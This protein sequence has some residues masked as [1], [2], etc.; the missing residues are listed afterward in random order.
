[1]S[2][3]DNIQTQSRFLEGVVSSISGQNTIKVTVSTLKQHRRYKKVYKSSKSYLAHTLQSH[4]IGDK[5]RLKVVRPISKRKSM[6]V[7][8]GNVEAADL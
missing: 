3:N 6:I 5:V 7:V 2:N 4:Q 8:N 1:M